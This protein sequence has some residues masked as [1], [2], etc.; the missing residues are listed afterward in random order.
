[1]KGKMK[2]QIHT[3][4]LH[5]CLLLHVAQTVFPLQKHKHIPKN[6]SNMFTYALGYRLPNFFMF[7][8]KP[9]FNVL[10][11]YITVFSVFILDK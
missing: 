10:F 8:A 9:V 7:V 4:L 11:L 6:V 1:M 5:N 2:I 3:C